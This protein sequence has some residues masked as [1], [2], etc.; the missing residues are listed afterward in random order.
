ML[1]DE[2]SITR[3]PQVAQLFGQR[4]PFSNPFFLELV[5]LIKQQGWFEKAAIDVAG[6][7]YI[8]VELKVCTLYNGREVLL[9]SVGAVQIQTDKWITCTHIRTGTPPERTTVY[10][11]ARRGRLRDREAPL[12]KHVCVVF[13]VTKVHA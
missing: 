10:L 13:S 3:T 5:K 11:V 6:R 1:K 12:V 7:Q 2:A 9:P 4:F 8:P